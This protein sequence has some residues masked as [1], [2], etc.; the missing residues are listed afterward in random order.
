[1]GQKKIRFALDKLKLR[2]TSTSGNELPPPTVM[3]YDGMT[4]LWEMIALPCCGTIRFLIS[5]PGLGYHPG[6]DKVI[7]DVGLGD[8]WVIPQDGATYYLSG[9]LSIQKEN[10]DHPSMG[11]SGI[12]ELP[13]VKIPRGK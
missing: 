8:V 5:F 7:V 12:I 9:R 1:M 2:V 13:K 3:A 11:W 10:G 6:T 4:P